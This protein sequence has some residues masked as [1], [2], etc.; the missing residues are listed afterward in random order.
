MAIAY[1]TSDAPSDALVSTVDK[2]LEEYNFSVAPSLTDVKPLA[3]SATD[4]G[5]LIG[6]AIGRTW[7]QCCELLELW[8]E[9]EFRSSGVGSGILICFENQA[10]QRGCRTFY[11][12]TLSFQAPDFYRKHGYESIASIA[13]Y[14]NG[15]IKYLMLKTEA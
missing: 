11:L 13:G 14:P 4:N 8:V 2:G 1:T 7:G 10:R 9:S 6:G 5:K 15:I 3:A 12:T